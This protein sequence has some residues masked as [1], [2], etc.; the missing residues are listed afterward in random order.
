M[1]FVRIAREHPVLES[2]QRVTG[3][4]MRKIQSGKH[5]H[6]AYSFIFNGYVFTNSEGVFNL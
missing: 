4:K 1:G 2:V 3:R 6:L 5:Q